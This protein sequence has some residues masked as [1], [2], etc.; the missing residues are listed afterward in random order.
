MSWY[1]VELSQSGDGNLSQE[2]QP[3]EEHWTALGSVFLM[4]GEGRIFNANFL[5]EQSWEILNW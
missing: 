2:L 5:E 4:F 1:V 3:V